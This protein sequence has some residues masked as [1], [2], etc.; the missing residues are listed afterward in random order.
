MNEENL[1]KNGIAYENLRAKIETIK[2]ICGEL[3]DTNTIKYKP[4][5]DRNTL[6]KIG[7]KIPIRYRKV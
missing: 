7:K 4:I 6:F 3:C 2:T 5:K 1:G